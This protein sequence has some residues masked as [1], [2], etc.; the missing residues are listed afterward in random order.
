MACM[1]YVDLNPIRAKMANT[2]E[3]SNHTSIKQ[4]INKAQ[5]ATQ[6]NHKRQQPKALLPFAGYPRNN[7][8][9]GL[10]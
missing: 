6:A 5:Q 9:K 3:T 7:M 4:R 1:A 8:P 10:P 2:P